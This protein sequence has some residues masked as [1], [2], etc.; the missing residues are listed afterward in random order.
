MTAVAAFI[1]LGG[2][3]AAGAASDQGVDQGIAQVVGQVETQVALMDQLLGRTSAPV[4]AGI[5]M[6]LAAINNELVAQQSLLSAQTLNLS[7]LPPSTQNYAYLQ[8]QAG[9]LTLFA[10]TVARIYPLG[11]A[12]PS[13]DRW[14]VMSNMF[15]MQLLMNNLA[16]VSELS[17]A[18]VSA[19]NSAITAMAR[20]LR[21]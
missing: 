18:A 1:T 7:T 4:T 17:T 14:N 20:N 6:R 21:G 16:Q 13:T 15:D 19:V 8:Q 2:G 11:L 12:P 9:N 10:A 3:T 5:P